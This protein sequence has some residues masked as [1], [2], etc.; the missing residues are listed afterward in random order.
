MRLYPLPF[1]ARLDIQEYDM[2]RNGITSKPKTYG[3]FRSSVNRLIYRG[4]ATKGKVA[5][6]FAGGQPKA[7]RKAYADGISPSAFVKVIVTS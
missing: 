6:D 7:L 2:S 3:A 4:K 1:P 5:R